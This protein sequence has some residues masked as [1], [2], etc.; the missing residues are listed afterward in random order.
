MLTYFKEE[1]SDALTLGMGQAEIGFPG[2][3]V[4]FGAGTG[5]SVGL[6]AGIGAAVARGAGTGAAVSRGAGA[7]VSWG[8]D[9][10]GLAGTGILNKKHKKCKNGGSGHV[11]KKKSSR[12]VL[13]K[14]DVEVVSDCTIVPVTEL[15]VLS[16]P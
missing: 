9:A 4:G 14:A 6:V 13:D 7:A 16:E 15:L 10:D 2:A 5:A 1:D 3:E 8:P 11:E 12:S